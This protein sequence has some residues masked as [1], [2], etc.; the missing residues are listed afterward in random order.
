MDHF[1]SFGWTPFYN[2]IIDYRGCRKDEHT[3]SVESVNQTGLFGFEIPIP[4][5]QC[6]HVTVKDYMATNKQT[7]NPP[8]KSFKWIFPPSMSKTF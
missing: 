3:T 4:A 6:L 2:I 5:S 1:F 7:K 8:K